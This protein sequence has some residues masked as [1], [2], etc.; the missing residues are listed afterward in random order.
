[1]DTLETILRRRSIRKYKNMPVDQNVIEQLL[2]AAMNSPSAFNKQPWEFIVID[3]RK[4][5]DAIPSFSEYAQMTKQAPLAILICAD[6]NIEKTFEHCIETCS[7]AT[8]NILLAAC[9]KGLG[10]VWTGIYPNKE[11]IEGYIK[12]LNL[13]PHIKPIS[14][15]VLGY[16]DESP[17]PKKNFTQKKIHKNSW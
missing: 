9:E 16:P 8:Q 14:L 10:A 2:M 13:P 5:L 6:N 15:I 1:M 7:A 4:K 3:D 12:L 17:S 11:K